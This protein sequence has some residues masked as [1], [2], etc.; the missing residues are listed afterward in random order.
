[1]VVTSDFTLEA[2]FDT[3]L[4]YPD[5]PAGFI[6]LWVRRT[7][8]VGPSPHGTPDGHGALA[9]TIWGS[10]PSSSAEHPCLEWRVPIISPEYVGSHSF[11]F[12]IAGPGLD[13]V[14]VVM[15]DGTRVPAP[16]G[17]AP[18]GFT[19]RAWLVESPPGD[20]DHVEGLAA[21]GRLIVAAPA[22]GD[23]GGYGCT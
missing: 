3:E 15:A 6:A 4:T 11:V 13:H 12:G 18:P 7:D 19:T 5:D 22:S 23:Y 1:M 8:G 20:V 17:T 2:V 16:I 21:D 14:E 10:N 9:G